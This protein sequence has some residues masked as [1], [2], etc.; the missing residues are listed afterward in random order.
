MKVLKAWK[1]SQLFER[2]LCVIENQICVSIT[3]KFYALT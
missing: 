3:K 1:I 2:I